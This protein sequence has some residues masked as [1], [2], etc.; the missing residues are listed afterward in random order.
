[1]KNIST[2]KEV[3]VNS[4]KVVEMSRRLQQFCIAQGLVSWLKLYLCDKPY[5]NVTQI[6]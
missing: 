2:C 5:L 3:K 6:K 1:M 4:H